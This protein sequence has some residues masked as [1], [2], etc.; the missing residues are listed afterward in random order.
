M[1]T[2]DNME[3]E[4]I[5]TSKQK[6]SPALINEYT[7]LI[8]IDDELNKCPYYSILLTDESE[9]EDFKRLYN[10]ISL[11][12]GIPS[13]AVGKFFDVTSYARLMIKDKSVKLTAAKLENNVLVIA[14]P[15]GKKDNGDII[16]HFTEYKITKGDKTNISDKTKG[17]LKSNTTN[18]ERY[19]YFQKVVINYVKDVRKGLSKLN[20]ESIIPIATKVKTFEE[21]KEDFIKSNGYEPDTFDFGTWVK[22]DTYRFDARDLDSVGHIV[23]LIVEYHEKNLT[24]MIQK[25]EEIEEIEPPDYSNLDE[26]ENEEEE[27]VEYDLGDNKYINTDI[28]NK[29]IIDVE[30][31]EETTETRHKYINE[32]QS[33]FFKP[34]EI[35][36]EEDNKLPLSFEET[37]KTRNENRRFFKSEPI[38][39]YKLTSKKSF[40]DSK[41]NKKMIGNI[42]LSFNLVKENHKPLTDKK[43]DK[44]YELSSKQEFGTSELANKI[45][46]SQSVPFSKGKE[47][48]KM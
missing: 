32:Y 34:S 44:K 22:Y 11:T 1:S 43:V 31:E 4:S 36:D 42:P 18:E 5:N 6:H 14:I 38:K 25:H 17:K 45:K 47:R 30:N 12:E 9:E 21:F 7:E 39:K 46:L 23:P 33:K 2:L 37:L 48:N 27:S 35:L 13:A 16:Y 20:D 40:A 19:N 24:N 8:K 26:E 41:V 28:S 3:I 10:S 29:Y 15:V